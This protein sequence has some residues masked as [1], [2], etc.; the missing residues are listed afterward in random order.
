MSV[1]KEIVRSEVVK[2]DKR[3]DESQEDFVNRAADIGLEECKRIIGLIRD[4]HDTIPAPTELQLAIVGDKDDE[5]GAAC[6]VYWI[7]SFS[8]PIALFGG[9]GDGA[10][11]T[12][13][14]GEVKQAGRLKFKGMN[15]ELFVYRHDGF[16]VDKE[17][18]LLMDAF[19]FS[20]E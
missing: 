4:E 14:D 7:P 3:E 13:E 19:R 10:V 5:G 12:D 9:P 11:C 20:E 15:E 16:F 6:F 2:I 8:S 17:N 1:I 18:G